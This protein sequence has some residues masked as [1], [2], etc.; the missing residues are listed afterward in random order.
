M[1]N[2]KQKT[3]KYNR[4]RINNSNKKNNTNN[5]VHKIYNNNAELIPLINI[6][7][8]YKTDVK[9]LIF[10]MDNVLFER[11][12]QYEANK[13]N[14]NIKY[15]FSFINN[16]N[17][18]YIRPG[19]IDFMNICI[20]LYDIGIFTSMQK[21][22]YNILNTIFDYNI[23][24]KFKFIY[25]RTHTKLDPEYN[26]LPKI[27]EFNTVKYLSDI[28][29]S[30]IINSKR[31]Y[32]KNNT[33]LVDDSYMKI[34]FNSPKNIIIFNYNSLDENSD[35]LEEHS[36]ILEEHS[37]TLDENNNTLNEHSDTLD[38]NNNTLN[39]NN[40]IL[41]EYNDILS[42]GDNNSTL[43]HLYKT[44]SDYETLI[45]MLESWKFK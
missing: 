12:K 8:D 11:V 41:E 27:T 25:T 6:K 43:K 7:N 40:T 44:C 10:D 39:E 17:I 24:K 28:F 21:N 38:E 26:I 3:R 32:N 22:V 2:N 42:N 16:N 33:I 9:L 34:R 18:Y 14:I 20:R 23:V 4:N 30:P 19:V 31:I 15:E 1:S 13:M 37:D 45:Y 36:D 35:I 29:T 5:I